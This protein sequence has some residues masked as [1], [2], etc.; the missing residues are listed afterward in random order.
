MA[1]TCMHCS[2]RPGVKY[3]APR[4]PSELARVAYCN[5]CIGGWNRQ[6]SEKPLLF[7]SKAEALLYVVTR[8]LE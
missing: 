1:K 7:K 8:A 5:K 2:Q 6:L 4:Y 3:W